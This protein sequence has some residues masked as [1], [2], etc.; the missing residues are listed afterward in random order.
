VAGRSES[1]DCHPGSPEVFPRLPLDQVAVPSPAVGRNAGCQG[2]VWWRVALVAIPEM[3]DEA[4]L[5]HTRRQSQPPYCRTRPYTAIH[6]G[7]EE[8]TPMIHAHRSSTKPTDA[9]PS[10]TRTQPMHTI[11]HHRQ[12]RATRSSTD[13]HR[14]PTM[15]TRSRPTFTE[16]QPT[17]TKH[18]RRHAAMAT[19]TQSQTESLLAIGCNTRH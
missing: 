12:S 16:A 18:H 13:A 19:N 9:T 5:L 15:P 10:P 7:H 4:R 14:G 3:V 11:A 17:L 8:I 6:S 2:V 1:P